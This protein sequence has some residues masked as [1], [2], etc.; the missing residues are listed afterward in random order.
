MEKRVESG[1]SSGLK[2]GFLGKAPKVSCNDPG[3]GMY[4]FLGRNIVFQPGRVLACE[5][6]KKISRNI[7][8]QHILNHLLCKLDG[9][10]LVIT[11]NQP[12]SILIQFNF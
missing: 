11:S 5:L 7:D 12:D 1:A 8:P 4:A 3:I 6:N 10:F 9:N 2:P